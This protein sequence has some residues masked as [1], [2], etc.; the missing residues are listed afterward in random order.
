[1]AVQAIQQKRAAFALQQVQRYKDQFAY[2]A[3]QGRDTQASAPDEE[4]VPAPTA[5]AQ[6]RSGKK[7][8][9][10]ASEL[11]FMIH[12]NGLGQALAFFKSKAAKN[13]DRDRYGCLYA[14]LSGWLTQTEQPF[15]GFD[16]A[17]FALTQCDQEVYLAAQSEAILLM[18][19]VKP[20]A[21]AFMG[22]DSS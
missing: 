4:Q 20:F 3:E 14:I 8:K 1:M 5:N 2:E 10:R 15:A 18:E 7:F 22:G 11:P 9:A 19:W 6:E 13:K 21:S 16:D 17:L 12:S